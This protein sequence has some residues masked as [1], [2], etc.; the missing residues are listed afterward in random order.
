M[1]LRT[2]IIPV[3]LLILVWLGMNFIWPVWQIYQENQAKIKKTIEDKNALQM[4]FN[5]LQR[6]SEHFQNL[7]VNDRKMILMAIPEKIN[8]DDL[9]AE[10]HK[11]ARQSGVLVTSLNIDAPDQKKC[12]PKP[13]KGVGKVEVDKSCL[14]ATGEKV[15]VNLDFV[16][17]YPSILTFLREFNIANRLNLVDGLVIRRVDSDF[18]RLALAAE[19]RE[20]SVTNEEEGGEE[21]TQQP[22][23]TQSTNSDNT[24]EEI[25]D[26]LTVKLAFSI[27]QKQKPIDIKLSE[28]IQ[29][30]ETLKTLMETGLRSDI[31]ESF[32]KVINGKTFYPVNANGVGKENPFAVRNFQ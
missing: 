30:D 24:A 15:M 16:G 1:N 14:A 18:D 5:N 25:S 6:A 22:S 13:T 7:P 31:L 27:Y 3:S 4:K 28:L 21:A 12:L 23:A 2:L 19:E 9:I 17:S 8:D 32:R 10:I 29:T 26:L 20:E 11:N